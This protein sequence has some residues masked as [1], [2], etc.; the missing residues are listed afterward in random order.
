ML[1]LEALRAKYGDSL[2]LH[3]GTKE[4]PR[5]AVID[6][7][8]PGVYN[9]ALKPR[10]DEIRTQ[11]KL[12]AKTPL[13]IDLMMVSHIDEDHIAGLLQLVRKIKDLRDA[14]QPVPWKI[15]RFW[16][17][18]FDDIIGNNDA[19]IASAASVMSTA[20]IGDLLRPEGSLV[21]ASVGQGR[22]LR[23]L[24]DALNLDG[25]PPFKDLVTAGHEEI[26]LG[27]LKLTVVAPSKENLLALQ[28][29][30]DKKIKP[31]LKKEKDAADRA[32]A[33]A[34]VDKSVYNLSS[35]VVLV[36]A[37]GKR[38]LLTGDGR[39][40]HT[41][42]GLEEAGL[43]DDDGK[44]EVDVLKMPHHGSIRNVDSDY[45]EKI[46]AR[47]Y[48]ISADGKFDNPD[49]DTLKQI[50]SARPDDDFTIH[51]TYPTDEFNVP[52]I[53]EAVGE[54]FAAEKAAGRKYKVET[55]KS[56]DLSFRIEL[57]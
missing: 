30:W 46:L 37:E 52:E 47:H 14:K 8:P 45:F 3:F 24:L 43:L 50:S 53:G 48:V 41:L 23:K 33:A 7:G 20:S 17:N 34:Y 2:I 42:A 38:I 11:R 57:A 25:N 40:D 15:R 44:I 6:G 28:E 26:T 35:I 9:E 18:S 10:L 13:E 36:E 32:E 29:D 21:L 12:D 51:L 56:D 39:G 27:N 31:I 4:Q 1:I 19:S 16:H 5:I 54:F 22:E 49:I 55:R